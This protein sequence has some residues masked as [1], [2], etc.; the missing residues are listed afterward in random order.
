MKSLLI[1]LLVMTY[2][3]VCTL[4]EFAREIMHQE[5]SFDKITEVELSIDNTQ[6]DFCNGSKSN[7]NA[8]MLGQIDA[9]NSEKKT[10]DIAE[11]KSTQINNTDYI[12][13]IDNQENGMKIHLPKEV[14]NTDFI[15]KFEYANGKLIIEIK[16][17]QYTNNCVDIKLGNVDRD[18]YV[19]AGL[20]KM[21][22]NEAT[23]IPVHLKINA[24]KLNFI[25]ND[26]V[27]LPLKSLNISAGSL[28]GSINYHNYPCK[29]SAG[30]CAFEIKDN[31]ENVLQ[32]DS[33]IK[34]SVG[35][36][37]VIIYS[38][39]A[40]ITLQS[41]V[42][43]WKNGLHNVKNPLYIKISGMM[44]VNSVPYKKK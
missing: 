8:K 9:L 39:R 42:K 31:D 23:T 41:P 11:I 43:Y 37:S 14:C 12:L 25:Q 30:A 13:K 32:S 27:I 16:N 35:G 34:I 5:Q 28:S 18:V 38:N 1:I 20:C 2:A 22:M 26:A 4:Q 6:I 3:P 15:K 10:N 40:Q 21:V 17:K 24:G 29:I 36:G 19:N 7:E 44:H 33:N